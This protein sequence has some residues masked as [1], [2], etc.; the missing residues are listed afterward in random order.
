MKLTSAE[1]EAMI[2]QRYVYDMNHPV[3][4]SALVLDVRR[5]AGGFTVVFQINPRT[6]LYC[7]LTKFMNCFPYHQLPE[8]GNE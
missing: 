5:N 2:W 1:R 4:M 8:V 3:E 7:G 6:P